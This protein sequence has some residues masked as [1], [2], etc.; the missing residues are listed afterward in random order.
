MPSGERNA[1][2]E[3]KQRLKAKINSLKYACKCCGA[4]AVMDATKPSLEIGKHEVNDRQEGLGNLP[5]TPLRDSGMAIAA[6]AQ[7][8]VTAPVVGDDGGTASD[9]TLDESV[10]RLGTAIRRDGKTNAS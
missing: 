8:R 7:L 1:L 6:L 3:E 10:Q 5:V 2:N 9:G 4:D